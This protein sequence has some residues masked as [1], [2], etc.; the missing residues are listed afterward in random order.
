MPFAPNRIHNLACGCGCAKC[1]ALRKTNRSLIWI[2][3][4]YPIPPTQL[5]TGC[6]SRMFFGCRFLFFCVRVTFFFVPRCFFAILLILLS[7]QKYRKMRRRQDED[8]NE[9]NNGGGGGGTRGGRSQ[10]IEYVSVY[11]VRFL[12][13]H[14]QLIYTMLSPLCYC[15]CVDICSQRI[16]ATFKMLSRG[17]ENMP[18][19]VAHVALQLN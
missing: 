15:T 3:H 9:N 5:A 18:R 16:C 1:S 4:F 6:F 7:A 14:M 8:F 10:H 12:H 17:V 11:T 13:I 2:L 19:K